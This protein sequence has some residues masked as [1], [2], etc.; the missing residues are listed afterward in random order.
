MKSKK[1]FFINRMWVLALLVLLILIEMTVVFFKEDVIF[2]IT[3][4][5]LDL[6]CLFGL[7]LLPPF[8]VLDQKGV[9]IHYLFATEEYLWK[10]AH[11]VEVNYDSGHGKSIPYLFDT[12]SIY[13]TSEGKKYFFMNGEIARSR[14]ARRLI[15]K[16]S[17]KK[18]EGFI[19]DDIKGFFEKRKAKKEKKQNR[20]KKNSKKRNK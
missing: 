15:E 9:R 19:S 6:V 11:T 10:N 18:I 1:H 4:L 3:M 17:G 8:Y 20:K 2:G 12:F 13:G 5:L 16:Y 14:R 7:L